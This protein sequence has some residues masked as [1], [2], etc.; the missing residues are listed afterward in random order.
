[1][2]KTLVFIHGSDPVQADTPWQFFH[3]HPSRYTRALL[4][5]GEIFDLVYFDF[6]KGERKEWKGWTA[7]RAKGPPTAAPDK[8]E[9]LKPKV[10][11]HDQSGNPYVPEREYP[12]V[13]AFY[14]WIKGQPAKSIVSLQIFSHGVTY[15]PV[16]FADSY[17]WRDQP[18]K[19]ADPSAERDPN[20]TE[21][22]LRDFDGA[23]PLSS[24]P[25]ATGPSGELGKFRAA[26][27]DDA[28]IKIW[29]C[30]E[31]TRQGHGAPI[32]KLI[33]DFLAT[34]PG[35]ANEQR[36]ATLV[37][38]YLDHVMEYFP[39]RL[40]ERLDLPVWAGPVGWGSDNFDIDG[41]FNKATYAR[42]KY[43]WKG[44]FPPNLRRKELWWR[45]SI[46]FLNSKAI[47]EK[48]FKSTLKAKLDVIGYVEYR[49]TWVQ[50]AKDAATKVIGP[51]TSAGSILNAP[52]ELMKELI[53]RIGTP[54]PE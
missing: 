45:V 50:A 12:S 7:T 13:L 41:T 24:D 18:D 20:D 31:Q 53:D 51:P 26:L 9:A 52:A 38:A 35:K 6:E 28:F 14:D 42:D 37:D 27:A 23:N 21:F 8:T 22:R 11:I 48:F 46:N 49:K 25:W 4:S 29:G 54:G 30:G 10:K 44:T 32:R 19:L 1:M 34:K 16:L 43:N 39:Y 33:A 47:I 15:Q 2:P 5:E 17:E 36:R 40:A 3:L